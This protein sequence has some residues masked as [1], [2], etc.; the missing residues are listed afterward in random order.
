[1]SSTFVC[2]VHCLITPPSFGCLQVK[3]HSVTQSLC[4]AINI[5]VFRVK[6]LGAKDRLHSGWDPMYPL[7]Y[8][9]GPFRVS[10][11]QPGAAELTWYGFIGPL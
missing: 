5:S 2:T 8:Y 3:F 9:E 6:K 4:F 11:V 7:V 10:Q 1:M